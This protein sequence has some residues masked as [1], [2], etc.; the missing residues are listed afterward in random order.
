MS[1]ER[2]IWIRELDWPERWLQADVIKSG[3]GRDGVSTITA[4]RGPLLMVRP[5]SDH[6]V[7]WWYL[8]EKRIDELTGWT[9]RTG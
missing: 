5:Q 9:E 3:T 1:G 2:A 4:R 7:T 6:G 8:G